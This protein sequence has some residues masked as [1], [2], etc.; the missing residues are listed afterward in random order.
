VAVQG[1][2]AGHAGHAGPPQSVPVSVPFFAPSLQDSASQKPSVHTLVVQSE[3]A[4]QRSPALQRGQE[5]PQ[6]VPVSVPFFTLSVH[7]EAWQ[8]FAVH[9]PDPQSAGNLQVAPARQ[10][11]HSLPPQSTSVSAPLARKSLQLGA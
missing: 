1:L 7:V 4:R 2:P 5:P 3:G 8:T 10:P 11:G 6:S 9:T